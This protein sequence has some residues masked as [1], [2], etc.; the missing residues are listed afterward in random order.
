M[1]KMS[2]LAYDIEQLYIDGMSPKQ[3]AAEL[4]CPITIVLEWLDL[5]GV[6]A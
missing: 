2:E 4:E 1:S 5:Q 3:I 6:D